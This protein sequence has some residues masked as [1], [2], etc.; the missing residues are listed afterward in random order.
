MLAVARRMIEGDRGVRAGGFPG[1]QSNHFAGAS[2][3]GKV[4]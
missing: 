3:Y 2:V 1:G 4:L